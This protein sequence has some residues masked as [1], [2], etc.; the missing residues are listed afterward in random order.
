MQPTGDG[1]TTEVTMFDGGVINLNLMMPFSMEPVEHME[2]ELPGCI[3][4]P[5]AS[6]VNK[7]RYSVAKVPSHSPSGDGTSWQ[8]R[9]SPSALA[10][11]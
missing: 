4:L 3:I 11:D 5:N 9:P 6:D 1:A 2:F 8:Q 10:T 7:Y